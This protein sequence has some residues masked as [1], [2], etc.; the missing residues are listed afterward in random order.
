MSKDPILDPLQDPIPDPVKDDP[1]KSTQGRIRHF[2]GNCSCGKKYEA[3]EYRIKLVC[4]CG[5]V[6]VD[7]SG[8][9]NP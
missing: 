6:V 5:Q 4:E 1:V 9:E 7:H 3:E 2:G 8:D